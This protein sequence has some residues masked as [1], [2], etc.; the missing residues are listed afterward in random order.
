MLNKKC[1]ILCLMLGFLILFSAP[2]PG[3]TAI[4]DIVE[5]E[6]EVTAESPIRAT[7]RV[8]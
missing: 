5:T 2:I 7:K 3:L 8:L 4:D 1:M 6:S